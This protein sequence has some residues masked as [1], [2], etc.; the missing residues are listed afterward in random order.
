MAK[1]KKGKGSAFEREICKELSYWWTDGKRDDIYWRSSNSG[2]R[3]TIRGR[4]GKT[5]FG[6]YGDVAAI[7]PIGAPLLDLAAIEIKR[8][9][10]EANFHCLLDRAKTAAQQVWESWIQQAHDSCE[11]SGSYGWMIIAK[12]DQREPLVVMDANVASVLILA[13]SLFPVT[14]KGPFLSGVCKIRHKIKVGKEISGYRVLTQ[15]FSAMR[16]KDWL[17]AVQPK[18]IRRVIQKL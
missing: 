7:D 11:G 10:S 14:E 5:T 17:K 8:G 13:G 1:A 3:A 9:Y 16:W 15:R 2:G 18:D 4:R 12:R 6:H